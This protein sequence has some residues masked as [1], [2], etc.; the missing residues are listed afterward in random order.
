EIVTQVER[1]NR[2]EPK[3]E[4]QHCAFLSDGVVDLA[5]R[6]VSSGDRFDLFTCDEAGDEK[7]QRCA[8]RGARR[9]SEKTFPQSERESGADGQDRSGRDR[10]STRLNSSH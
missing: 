9:N 6:F 3:Q 7:G 5:E 8:E 2:T 1:D 4:N 10:K